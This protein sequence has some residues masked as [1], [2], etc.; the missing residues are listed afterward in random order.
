MRRATYP[1]GEQAALARRIWAW[2][3]DWLRAA[4]AAEAPM[5]VLPATPENCGFLG[6]SP[7][8]S[9]VRWETTRDGLPETTEWLRSRDDLIVIGEHKEA[10]SG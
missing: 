2:L 4:M 9:G 1:T 3:P 10:V 7:R 5:I 6:W 8:F